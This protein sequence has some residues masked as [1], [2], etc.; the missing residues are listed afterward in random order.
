MK[1]TREKIL[2]KTF[3]LLIRKGYDSVSVSDIQKELGMSRG[4]LYCYFKNKSDLI[5]AVCALRRA[6]RFFLRR[7]K[8]R[9][10]ILPFF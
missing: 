4:L 9:I 3:M 7:N 10:R 2:E 5:L 1:D 8:Y 6:R